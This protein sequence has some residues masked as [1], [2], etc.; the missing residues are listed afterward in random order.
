MRYVHAG[1]LLV[2]TSIERCVRSLMDLYSIV[3]ELVSKGGR[4]E[5]PHGRAD[6]LEGLDPD[7]QID[8]GTIGFGGGV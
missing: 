8:A 7:R 6:L 2:V 3:D 1:E 4:G 5:I